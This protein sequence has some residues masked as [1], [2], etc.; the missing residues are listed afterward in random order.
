ML[1]TFAKLVFVARLVGLI[2]HLLSFT[3][4]KLIQNTDG[5]TRS[6]VGRA[7]K[8][9]SFEELAPLWPDIIRAVKNPSPSGIMFNGVIRETGV[10]LVMEPEARSL[11]RNVCWVF[12]RRGHQ[13]QARPAEMSSAV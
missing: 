10:D 2:N 4:R 11:V 8:L 5:H 12:D 7:L 3:L 6:F 1:N 13:L 9:M